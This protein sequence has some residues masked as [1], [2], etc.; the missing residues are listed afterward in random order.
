MRHCTRLS[1]L[2]RHVVL[3]TLCTL[4][5]TAQAVPMLGSGNRAIASAQAPDESPQGHEHRAGIQALVDGSLPTAK[6]HFEASLKID[7][8]YAPALIGLASVAQTEHK[9]ADAE[10]YLQRAE[11]AAPLLP[12]V[13]LAWGRYY[14]AAK[15]LDRAE[16]SLLES[17]RLDGKGIPPLLELGDLYLHTG[18]AADALNIYRDAVT[19]D[20][21]NRFAQFGL[22]TA[23]A[24]AGQREDALR[25]FE[26]A[27]KL[28]PQDPAPLRAIGLIHMETGAVDKA[29]V[30]F[31]TGLVRQPKFLPLMLDRADALGHQKRWGDALKQLE[32]AEKLAPKSAEVQLKMADIYQG[33]QRWSEAETRYLKTIELEPGKASAYNNLAWMTVARAGDPKVAV[34]WSRKAVELSPGS[35]PFHDTLGWALRAA[36]DLQGARTR[37]QQAIKLEPKVAGYHFHLGVVQSELKQ[38]AAARESLKLALGLDLNMPQAEEARRLLKSLL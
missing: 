38:P 26:V 6:A 5:M 21:S 14:I 7:P 33:A 17:R 11:R 22:G 35:S 23:A 2:A 28:A 30:A 19:L 20:A 10:Q 16:R 24:V 13:H 36:G 27:A 15:K 12:A 25:A 37:L 3:A 34:Q 29:I 8:H 4:A 1:Q 9:P 31:D 32:Q 18:R